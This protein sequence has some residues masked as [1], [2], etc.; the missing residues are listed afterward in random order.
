MATLPVKFQPLLV[1]G[2]FP[3]RHTKSTRAASYEG[4]DRT[5]V[6]GLG[7]TWVS[8]PRDAEEPSI[9]YNSCPRSAI[10]KAQ[11][12]FLGR[13]SSV[14]MYPKTVL[15]SPVDPLRQRSFYQGLFKT[16]PIEQDQIRRCSIR[17]RVPLSCSPFFV[18][19]RSWG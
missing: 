6:D 1:D 11:R 10:K 7:A 16:L 18:Q 13:S 15:C 8:S 19:N 14:N 3:L 4:H 12:I 17:F 2:C 5:L 9:P